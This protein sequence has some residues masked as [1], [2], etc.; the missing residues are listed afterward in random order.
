M[1]KVSKYFWGHFEDITAEIQTIT[2]PHN[3]SKYFIHYIFLNEIK[4]NNVTNE[5]MQRMWTE[6]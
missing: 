4:A 3:C 5:A 2:F 6:M 1:I